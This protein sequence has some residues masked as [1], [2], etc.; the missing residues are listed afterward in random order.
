MFVFVYNKFVEN[1][2]N[3]IVKCLFVYN[4]FVE[5][6]VN[7]IVKCLQETLKIKEAMTDFCENFHFY[8][9]N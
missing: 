9:F 7:S 2:V 8:L 3:S 4:K 1:F 5:N 6:F